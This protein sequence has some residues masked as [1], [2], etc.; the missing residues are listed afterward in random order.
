MNQEAIIQQLKGHYSRD[1]RK[2]LVKSIL[3]AE[4]QG[5]Q[6]EIERQYKIINQ[7]FSFVLQESGWRIGSDS[8]EW[9]AQPM[10]VMLLVFPQLE[11]TQWY[12]DQQ[13]MVDQKIEVV[14]PSTQTK[15]G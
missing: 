3:S 7:I 1:L 2:Q 13:L 8:K 14:V 4:K 11:K 10:E 12:Q 5:D 9:N 6:F 15:E